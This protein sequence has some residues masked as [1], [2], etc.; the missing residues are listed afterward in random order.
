[1]QQKLARPEDR[2]LAVEAFKEGLINVN[3]NL[4]GHSTRNWARE[5][6]WPSPW[7]SFKKAFIRK[8]LENDE[9]FTD[10]LESGG[11]EVWIPGY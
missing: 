10:A 7:F 3:L 8:M 2:L 9:N 4:H 6:H 1:M 11:I 5:K